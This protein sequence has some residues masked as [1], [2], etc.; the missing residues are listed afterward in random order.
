[1]VVCAKLAF[2]SPFFSIMAATSIVVSSPVSVSVLIQFLH[3]LISGFG[4]TCVQSLNQGTEVKCFFTF[5]T[6]GVLWWFI[7][8]SVINR[9]L[10]PP[11]VRSF[12]WQM[13]FFFELIKS[14][15]PMSYSGSQ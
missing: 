12:L 3:L 10:A 2:M 8:A 14:I 1:M 5:L 13:Q 7:S 4:A 6:G 11:V 9:H 15:S